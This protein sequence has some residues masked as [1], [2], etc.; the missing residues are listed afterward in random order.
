MKHPTILRRI[1]LVA[2]EHSIPLCRQVHA[3]SE[4]VQLVENLTVYP[5]AGEIKVATRQAMP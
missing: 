2:R 4:F 3:L 1:D 5:L